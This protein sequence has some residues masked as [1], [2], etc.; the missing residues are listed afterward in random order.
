MQVYVPFNENLVD[1]LIRR[2]NGTHRD[3][4]KLVRCIDTASTSNIKL[5]VFQQFAKEKPNFIIW[6]KK[7]RN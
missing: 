4:T 3:A 1:L 6:D 7:I 5:A 2:I